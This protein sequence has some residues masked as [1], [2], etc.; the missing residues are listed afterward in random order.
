M[1]AKGRRSRVADLYPFICYVPD[2]QHQRRLHYYDSI[3]RYQET[4]KDV[5]VLDYD[6][7][8]R[9]ETPEPV[10]GLEERFT[11][12][13]LTRAF[14]RHQ[15]RMEVIEGRVANFAE[16]LAAHAQIVGRGFVVE[17]VKRFID[18]H[19]RGLLLI[20]AEPG[21]GKTAL[22]CHLIENE[23]AAQCAAFKSLT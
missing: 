6:D 8:L 12:E 7:G 15:G 18:E 11:R 10:P 4:R 22:I 2:S 1:K 13:L 17:Y 14:R 5:R 3:Y 9:R 19:D 20:E 16:L 23:F 21:K